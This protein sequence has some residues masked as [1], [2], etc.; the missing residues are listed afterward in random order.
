MYRLSTHLKK[1][2]RRFLI[3]IPEATYCILYLF[4][5]F[6]TQYIYSIHTP[7]TYSSWFDC[8]IA[9]LFV[10]QMRCL[11]FQT[12]TCCLHLYHLAKCGV[13]PFWV[14]L[15]RFTHQ[16]PLMLGKHFSILILNSHWKAL[17]YRSSRLLFGLTNHAVRLDWQFGFV[18]LCNTSVTRKTVFWYFFFLR[19]VPPPYGEI[20][21][22]DLV[23]LASY[24]LPFTENRT[25]GKA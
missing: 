1:K 18:R 20:L 25:E 7:P 14:P 23:T 12:W 5:G 2:I 21:N 13:C 11:L 15:L 19:M 6:P 3:G 10:R 22:N 4:W 8:P 16:L 9:S 24:T 17:K